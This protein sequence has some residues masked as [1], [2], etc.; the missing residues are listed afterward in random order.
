MPDGNWGYPWHFPRPIDYKC[1]K[2]A[3][4][5]CHEGD[6][7]LNRTSDQ[8]LGGLGVIGP[9]DILKPSA[10]FD[11]VYQQCRNGVDPLL[12]KVDKYV[13]EKEPNYETSHKKWLYQGQN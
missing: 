9:E 13:K 12:I 1:L 3:T 4:T 8:K 10:C 5:R 11:S 2:L 7:V 6:I